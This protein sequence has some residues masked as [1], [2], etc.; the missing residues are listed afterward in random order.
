M[1]K[2]LIILLTIITSSCSTQGNHIFKGDRV[3]VLFNGDFTLP[4]LA[5]SREETQK[6]AVQLCKKRFGSQ[7]VTWKPGE[8]YVTDKRCSTKWSGSGAGF[9]DAYI[10]D[11]PIAKTNF[12]PEETETID[13]KLNIA[14]QKCKDRN[15]TPGTEEFGE[16]VLKLSE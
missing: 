1:K 16:C 15:L 3:E 4:G 12:S 8:C 11:A 13:T 10:C 7:T 6:I 5:L 9:A 2:I 14:K